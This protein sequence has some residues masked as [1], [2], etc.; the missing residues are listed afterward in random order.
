MGHNALPDTLRLDNIG[1]FIWNWAGNKLGLVNEGLQL[2][3]LRQSPSCW[4]K[5]GDLF[6]TCDWCSGVVCQ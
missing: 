1:L 3:S 2:G 6:T 5:C 4:Y